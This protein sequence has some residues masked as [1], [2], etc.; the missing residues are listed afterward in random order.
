VHRFLCLD[1]AEAEKNGRLRRQWLPNAEHR[2]LAART[3]FGTSPLVDSDAPTRR[4]RR[5]SVAGLGAAGG[6]GYVT[7]T[8]VV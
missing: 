1:K 3:V 5:R 7:A 4:G 6:V 2:G 8:V